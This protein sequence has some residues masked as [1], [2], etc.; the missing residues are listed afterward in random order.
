MLGVCAEF[1]LHL[2]RLPDGDPRLVCKYQKKKDVGWQSDLL[3]CYPLGAQVVPLGPGEEP[4]HPAWPQEAA[5]DVSPACGTPPDPQVWWTECRLGV[6]QFEPHIPALGK[7]VTNPASQQVQ[8]KS[9]G[10]TCP[11]GCVWDK[12]WNPCMTLPEGQTHP[13]AFQ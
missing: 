6:Q 3:T 8:L 2:P 12:V 1:D 9:P 4:P 13:G 5:N 7:A 10:Y 11:S